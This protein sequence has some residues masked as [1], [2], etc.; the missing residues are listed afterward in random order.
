M[1]HDLHIIY[2]FIFNVLAHFTHFQKI[3]YRNLIYFLLICSLLNLQLALS[4]KKMLKLIITG[5]NFYPDLSSYVNER[6]Q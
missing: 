1:Y 5:L 2:L 6:K 4:E 3:D